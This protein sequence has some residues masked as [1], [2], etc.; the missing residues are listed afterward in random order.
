MDKEE[1]EDI[2]SQMDD[3]R[4]Q[5]EEMGERKIK[6]AKMKARQFAEMISEK[7]KAAGEKAKMAGRD[8]DKFAHEKPWA[9]I[10]VAAAVGMIA[11]LIVGAGAAK[12]KYKCFHE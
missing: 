7:S 11:G 4:Q 8:I 12:K 5:L 1:M 6:K 2:E 9:A 10:G 3:L